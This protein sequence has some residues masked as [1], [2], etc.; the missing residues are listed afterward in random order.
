MQGTVDNHNGSTAAQNLRAEA[1]ASR[2]ST[3]DKAAGVLRDTSQNAD[4]TPRGYD[5]A[6][7][8][9]QVSRGSGTLNS[10]INATDIRCTDYVPPDELTMHLCIMILKV[11][12][13]N[14]CLSF[15]FHTPSLCFLRYQ[16]Q[17]YRRTL[18]YGPRR[19]SEISGLLD[20]CS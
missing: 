11:I 6:G 18:Q 14:L 10:E 17:Y 12:C 20:A 15:G 7:T 5:R 8:P 19:T 9:K 1:R 4:I 13:T 2:A 3:V 16:S